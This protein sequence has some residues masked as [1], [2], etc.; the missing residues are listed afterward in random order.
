MCVCV[1]G[2][3]VFR[4][5]SSVAKLCHDHQ[6]VHGCAFYGMCVYTHSAGVEAAQTVARFCEV[7]EAV[8]TGE[9]F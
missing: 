8:L 2:D 4:Y 7:N 1:V 5:L 6:Q 3:T 9:N